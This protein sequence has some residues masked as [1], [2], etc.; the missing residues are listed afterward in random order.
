MESISPRSTGIKYGIILAAVA[1]L[2]TLITSMGPVPQPGEMSPV[3]MIMGLLGF[4]VPIAIGV[5]GLREFRN[6]NEG[7]M[8]FGQGFQT[9]MW[10][11]VI[12]YGVASVLS[13]VY[14]SFFNSE[15]LDESYNS[16]MIQLE[17]TPNM[18]EGMLDLFEGVY[19]FMFSPMGNL[20]MGIVSGFLMGAIYSLIISAIMKKDMPAGYNK[21]NEIGGE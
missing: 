11:Y 20:I 8:S 9:G 7:F 18:T 14:Y 2:M 5:L 13:F 10:T 12:G 4:A 21:I 1:F 19:G 17:N 16:V 3:L 15:Y 6:L